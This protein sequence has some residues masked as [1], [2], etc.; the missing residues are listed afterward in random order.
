M[1]ETTRWSLVLAAGS[2][3]SKAAREA[4]AALCETYWYPLYA[5][6]R[7]R[8]SGVEDARDLTQA[9][10][11]S[12]I[13]RRDFER[14]RRERGRFRAFLL[15]RSST[16]WRTKPH[17]AAPRSMAAASPSCRLCAG[18]GGRG[19]PLRFRTGGCV[20]AG[21]ALRAPLGADGH[22]SCA[23]RVASGMDA[24][25]RA[26]EF[27]ELKAC[28]MRETPSGG[29]GVAARLGVTEG[30]VK[31]AHRLR[32][33]PRNSCGTT[34]RIPRQIRR[35]DTKSDTCSALNA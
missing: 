34:S 9:F 20:H 8:G 1:F 35:T 14:V 29:A 32:R 24:K 2:D 26:E 25:A 27:D 13:E 5:Y 30:A 28:L 6:A 3:D 23:R 21:N 12:L 31:V 17:T 7:R 16:S 22:R 11:T 4:L 19:R 33:K 10:L 15:A 18:A